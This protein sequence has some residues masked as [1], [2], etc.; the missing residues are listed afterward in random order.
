M[1]NPSPLSLAATDPNTLALSLQQ[2]CK[3]FDRPVVD[4]LSLQVR[5][6][7]IY[8]LLGSNGAGKT[9]T[10]RMIAGLL[11]PDSGRIEVLGHDLATAPQAA[12]AVVA[13][14]PDDPM[15][16]D[17]LKP[18]EYLEFVA[19]LWGIAA[20][21]ALERARQ[22]LDWMGLQAHAGELTEGFSRGM[23]QKLALAGALI[24]RPQLII[25]DE[26]LTGLD[27]HAARQ[28]KDVLQ[29]HVA[30]GGTVLITTHILEVAERIAHRIGVIKHGR[31]LAEGTLA[32]LQTQ[33]GMAD[34]SLEDIFLHLTGAA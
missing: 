10:L 26:P 28:V 12:K 6:G 16:Y 8:A 31:L 25:L 17:K 11:Q 34:A 19:G 4:R 5:S 7:E 27:A 33:A 1:L 15:L 21:V 32:E 14:L 18:Y 9:T 30:D 2:V 23:K 22:L 20:P 24:H 13:Y 3:A 29:Q